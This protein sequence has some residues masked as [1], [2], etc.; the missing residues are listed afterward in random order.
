MAFA[1]PTWI[2]EDMDMLYKKLLSGLLGLCAAC[3]GPSE[4]NYE[5][6]VRQMVGK[7][8]AELIT[9]W[10]EPTQVINHGRGQ[11]YIYL[12]SRAIP[13]PETQEWDNIGP[14]DY[15]GPLSETGIYDVDLVCQTTF[16][17]RNDKVTD[18]LFDGNACKS[19]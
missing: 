6:R 17:V 3:A 12:W 5:R 18:W 10:G 14:V 9:A 19:Y 13:L 1:I 4:Q 15:I 2:G 7:T 11:Y 8:P 16:V